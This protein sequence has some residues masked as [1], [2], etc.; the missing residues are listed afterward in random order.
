MR[1]REDS[2]HF[3]D[4]GVRLFSCYGDGWLVYRRKPEDGMLH[5]KEN[6]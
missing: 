6:S 5:G 4:G 3:T 2:I 1:L